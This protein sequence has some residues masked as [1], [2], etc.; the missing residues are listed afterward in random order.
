MGWGSP[1]N[2]YL[3]G[4]ANKKT[5]DAIVSDITRSIKGSAGSA[6]ERRKYYE[7]ISMVI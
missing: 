6:S 5:T 2:N 3:D 7:I 1:Q 4:K